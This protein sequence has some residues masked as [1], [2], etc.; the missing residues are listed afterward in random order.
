LLKD[1]LTQAD[2]VKFASYRPATSDG[3]EAMET[4]RR[5]V[6]ETAPTRKQSD[7]NPVAQEA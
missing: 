6:K 4:A 3:N 1:F 2:I 7:P 5:F